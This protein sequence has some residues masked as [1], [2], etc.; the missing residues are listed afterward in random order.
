MHTSNF[1]ETLDQIVRKDSRYH[2][3]AYSFVREALD[4]TQKAVAKGGR[5]AS[6]QEVRH[7]SGQELLKASAAMPWNNSGP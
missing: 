7:V 6:K 5:D 1:E 4:H 2:R 3:D